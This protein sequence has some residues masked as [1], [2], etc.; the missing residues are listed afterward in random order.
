MLSQLLAK[1]ILTARQFCYQVTFS[2]RRV[3]E[4]GATFFYKAVEYPYCRLCKM[5]DLYRCLATLAFQLL[6]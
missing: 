5:P 6:L 3:A 4:F 2:A 1:L